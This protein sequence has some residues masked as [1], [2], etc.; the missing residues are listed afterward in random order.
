GPAQTRAQPAAGG[1]QDAEVRPA[2]P[3]AAGEVQERPPA[4]G[5]GDAAAAVRT[6]G[7]PP[8]RLLARAAADP[9]VLE[10]VPRAAELPPGRG[11]QLHL[12]PAGRRVL[13]RGGLVR[14]QAVE[15]DHPAGPG[16]GPV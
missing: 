3:E 16:T 10:P 7:E 6:R 9:G 12:R 2:D 5:A 15:L 14:R 13:H 8:R 11:E 4:H 1:P